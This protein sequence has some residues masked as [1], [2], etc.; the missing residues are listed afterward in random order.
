M[1]AD[2]WLTTNDN[3]GGSNIISISAG[4]T[5]EGLAPLSRAIRNIVIQSQ[6]DKDV[7]WKNQ[8]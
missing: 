8:T 2:S 3:G 6:A 7:E 5:G 1:L 4:V